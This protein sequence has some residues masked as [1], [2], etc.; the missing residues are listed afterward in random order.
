M[1]QCAD[2]AVFFFFN[3]DL[4]NP[5]LN[6][7]MPMISDIGSGPILF[8]VSFILLFSKKRELKLLGL[9]LLA[10]L[11]VSFYLVSGLKVLVARPRP[12]LVLDGVFLLEKAKSMSFPSNH[13]ATAFMAAS[14]LTAYFKRY[15]A[16][17]YSLAAAVAVSRV[18]MGVH[19]PSDV[20]AGA[21]LGIAIGYFLTKSGARGLN[22]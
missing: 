17:F 20:L 5:F 21:G 2:R 1:L 19:Y 13:A 16:V 11:T 6:F 3:H 4:S 9:I 18:Y 10:G 12:S 14:V 7:V 15:A 22:G 8:T